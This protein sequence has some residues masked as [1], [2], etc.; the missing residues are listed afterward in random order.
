MALIKFDVLNR[1]TGAV[2]FTA[3]IECDEDAA[4]SV[5]LGLAV[6]WG[7]KARANLTGAN[8]TGAN[9]TGANLDGANLDGANLARANLDGANLARANLTGANLAGANLARAN[10][11]GANLARA[12]LAGANLAGANLDGAAVRSLVARATRSDGYEFM[13]YGTD[14]GLII[15]AGCRTFSLAEFRAHVAASYPDTPK[16]TETTDIL[17]FIEKRAASVVPVQAAA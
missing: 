2:N 12:N 8:L 16:A 14:K 13:A 15:R 5:K 11:D 4:T 3:E 10:L 6:K 9:L 7:V 1:F 17:D